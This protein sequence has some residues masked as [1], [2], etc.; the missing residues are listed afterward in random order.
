MGEVVLIDLDPEIF[1]SIEQGSKIKLTNV[2]T[3]KFGSLAWEDS[4]FCDLE[5]FQR[6][7]VSASV[8]RV[9]Y[10]IYT[11]GDVCAIG[12]RLLGNISETT[13]LYMV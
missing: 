6:S 12:T 2:K 11:N 8:T 9:A 7:R 3:G 5:Q 10:S 4:V 13:E 1:W